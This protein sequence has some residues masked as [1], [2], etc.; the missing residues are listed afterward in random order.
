MSASPV[1]QQRWSLPPL[2][3]AAWLGA[4]L[5]LLFGMIGL[6]GPLLLSGSPSTQDLD[7]L[8][9]GPSLHSVIVLRVAS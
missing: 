4:L 9:E 3:T 5:L 1:A 2:G 6:I 8:L 7:H